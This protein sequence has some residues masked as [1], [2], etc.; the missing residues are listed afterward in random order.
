MNENAI[1]VCAQ[2]PVPGTGG[3]TDISLRVDP[4]GSFI[5]SVDNLQ[6]RLDTLPEGAYKMTVKIKRL[7]ELA[8]KEG[9]YVIGQPMKNNRRAGRNA[10]ELETFRLWRDDGTDG[11]GKPED[12]YESPVELAR[13][14]ELGVSE[15]ARR[16]KVSRPTV[17]RY[18]RKL[19]EDCK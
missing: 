13:I 4:D 5:A 11:E 6:S 3:Y 19:E 9:F 7:E 12:W 1:F 15:A 8:G 2:R 18:I 16:L 17:Y 10:K 14:R